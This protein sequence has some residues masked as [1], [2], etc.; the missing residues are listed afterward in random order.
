MDASDL[1]SF[2]RSRS[3]LTKKRGGA[4]PTGAAGATATHS[5]ATTRRRPAGTDR[6]AAPVRW[7]RLARVTLLIVLAGIMLLYIGPLHSLWVTYHQARADRVQVA[8][9]ERQNKQLHARAAALQRP[10]SVEQAAR[11]IG[12][13]RPGELPYVI[14]GLPSG[15]R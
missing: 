5:P 9:L 14:S 4:R 11:Q 7:D 3:A 8:Q 10:G 6:I 1:L 15:H 12:M 13:I 2:P